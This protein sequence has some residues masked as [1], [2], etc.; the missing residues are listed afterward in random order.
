MTPRSTVIIPCYNHGHYL[1]HTVNSVLAQTF[2]DWEAIIVDDGSNDDTRAVA[3]QF[4]DPRIHYIY[5]EN[6]GLAAARN[7][8]IAEAQGEWI[9]FLDADDL[10]CPDF[11][12]TMLAHTEEVNG[13]VGV[14]ISGW[15][16]ATKDGTPLGPSRS[17][18]AT[19][20]T[21]ERLL[22]GNPCPLHASIT[23]QTCIKQI[24]GF[25]SGFTGVED[26]YFLLS[27]AQ[28]GYHFV[29][30][31]Q[32]LVLYR[33]V[34]G[35]MSRNVPMMRDNGLRVLD[36]IYSRNDLS[37]AALRL[38]ESAYGRVNLWAGAN[39]FGI[40]SAEAGMA[41]FIDAI[42]NY[43]T[44]LETLD[45][46]YAILCA[47]QP[48]PFKGSEEALDLDSAETRLHAVLDNV[49]TL[50]PEFIERWCNCSRQLS[51]I[52]LSKLA[53]AQGQYRRSGSYLLQNLVHRPSRPQIR[54]LARVLTKG[55]VSRISR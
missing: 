37:E 3:A 16:Y 18:D 8:G 34:P 44:L 13:H 17:V 28:N 19:E 6:R 10:W 15:Q 48:L 50:H 42:T 51:S 46:Y 30:I 21:F 38:K 35:S 31:P 52:A 49:F 27:I 29:S 47:E 36:E 24:G 2:S 26:W 1:S 53:E 25:A 39:Y 9:A 5:Q 55:I 40:G 33:Q 12:A 4:D 43:P 23:R 11:A 54:Q 22:L 32:T 7:R 41:Q 20:I 45:T 14:I